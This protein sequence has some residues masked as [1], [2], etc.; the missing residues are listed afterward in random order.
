MNKPLVSVIMGVYNCEDTLPRAIES[1]LAQTYREW[2]LILCDDASVD[3][4]YSVAQAY[5]RKHPNIRVLRNARNMRLAYSLNQCMK[6]AKGSLIARMDGDD[7][8]LPERFEKQVAF[9]Q[10]HPE[11]AMVGSAIRVRS[12]EV[13][14]GVRWKNKIPTVEQ[15]IHGTPFLHPTI[16]MRKTVFDDLNGYYVSDRTKRGQD[17]DLWFRF[18]AKGYVGYNLQEP[19]L[20][21]YADRQDYQKKRKLG[22]AW[23]LTKTMLVG[24]RMNRFPLHVYPMALKPVI[25]ALIPARI[26]VAYHNRQEKQ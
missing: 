23:G 15:M 4:T 2:E 22:A 9:L 12:S 18:F 1:L 25:S 6:E 16:M 20:I 8:S 19:L 14:E 7:V 3:G 26:M 21:Y 10:N 13:T 5:A 24:F 11:Y 17:L